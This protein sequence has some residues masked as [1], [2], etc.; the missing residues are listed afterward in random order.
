MG[1]IYQKIKDAKVYPLNA[2]GDNKDILITKELDC[3]SC[4]KQIA[5]EIREKLE[6][7]LFSFFA[8]DREELELRNTPK[9]SYELW[10]AFWQKREEK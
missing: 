10:Q 1:Y 5:Q 9:H 6:R 3:A 4:H 2:N 8:I 7:E